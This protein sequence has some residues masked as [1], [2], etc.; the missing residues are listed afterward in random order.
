MTPGQLIL[1]PTAS[2]LLN[3]A[4]RH[5]CSASTPPAPGVHG[6]CGYFAA[7]DGTAGSKV[8]LALSSACFVALTNQHFPNKSVPRDDWPCLNKIG[9]YQ[10]LKREELSGFRQILKLKDNQT[11]SCFL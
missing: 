2:L 6:M 11:L 8:S 4:A 7:G 5:F 10:V 9:T 1:R 3:S